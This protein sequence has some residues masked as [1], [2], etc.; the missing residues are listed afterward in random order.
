MPADV[1]GGGVVAM[2]IQCPRCSTRWRVADSSATENPVFKC[3]RCHHV[4]PRFPGAPPQAER[5]GGAKARGAPPEPDNL[6]FIFPGRKRAAEEE[7][8]R[9]EVEISPLSDLAPDAPASER[10][11]DAGLA[12]QHDQAGAAS[13]ADR[14]EPAFTEQGADGAEEWNDDPPWTE[15]EQPD[16]AATRIVDG[17]ATR[18]VEA[19]DEMAPPIIVRDEPRPAAPRSEE[20]TVRAPAS[21]A[22]TPEPDLTFELDDRDDDGE[23]MFDERPASRVLDVEERMSA[24]AP[25]GALRPVNRVLL[26]CVFGYAVLALVM[27]ANPE[28]TEAWLARLPFV[29]VPLTTHPAATRTITLGDVRGGYQ[30]LRTGRRIFVI[31]GRATN[32]SPVPVDRIEVEGALYAA[33]G[34]VD[35]KVIS[36]GNR[37]T[38]K[39]RELSESEIN[40]LQGL[41]A[42]QPVAPGGSVGFSIVFLEPPRDLREFS[43]RV[44]TVQSPSRASGPP[45]D[46]PRIP[47]SV[48]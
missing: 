23:P 35:R 7:R 43:S 34:A 8:E 11:A 30:Q 46:P 47:A 18:I 48:G 29:G 39:L 17:A 25:I 27:R 6:E 3:G 44:L 22:R 24:S 16:D 45:P 15:D 13:A 36:T 41:D 10:D 12:P 28:R 33:S 38:L 31:S 20:P 21:R 5:N 32:N 40:L 19:T 2:I 42:R 26:T 4:F 9:E 37:T 1:G 14:G